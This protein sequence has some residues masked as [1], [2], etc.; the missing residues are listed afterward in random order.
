MSSLSVNLKLKI[1]LI[2]GED[3]GCQPAVYVSVPYIIL[4]VLPPLIA[5]GITL[6]LSS[7]YFIFASRRAADSIYLK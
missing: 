5:Q 4:G 2:A 1:F 6:V 7:R 3:F